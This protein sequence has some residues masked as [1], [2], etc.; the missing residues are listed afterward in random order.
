MD[1]V[2]WQARWEEGRIG[3]HQEEI[4]PY[5]QRYWPRLNVPAGASVFVPLCGKS[6]D[7]LWLRERGHL[8]IGV[9]IVARAAEDFFAENNIEA[10]TYQQDMLTVWEGEGVKLYC[11]D[12]FRLDASNLNEVV[13]VYDRAS[14]VA[15]PPELRSRYAAHLRAILPRKAGVLL[16][17]MDYAQS[18]M[19]GPPFAVSAEEVETLYGKHFDIE[20]VHAEDILAANAKFREQ[21]ITR[22]QEKVFLLTAR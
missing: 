6:K 5:L 7:M 20:Q 13:A 19:Q 12:F 9:E 18:E 14:L 17:T 22:L 2:F 11:G 1:K 16:V 21:G 15:L 8:V 10:D 3:F 4:N